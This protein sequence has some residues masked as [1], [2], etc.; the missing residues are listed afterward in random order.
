MAISKMRGNWPPSEYIILYIRDQIKSNN[1]E[2]LEM[3]I[4]LFTFY[5]TFLITNKYPPFRPSPFLTGAKDT[6]PLGPSP[7]T[8]VIAKIMCNV[9]NKVKRIRRILPK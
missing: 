4:F 5:C 7:Y 1:K 3:E 2:N 6:S 8:H 9:C